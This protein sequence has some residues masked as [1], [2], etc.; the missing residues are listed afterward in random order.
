MNSTGFLLKK[1]SSSPSF[2]NYVNKVLQTFNVPGVAVAIVKDGKVLSAKGYGVKK[3]GENNK[4]DEN[5]IILNCFK[6]K[7]IHSNGNGH[8]CWKK[9]K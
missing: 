4:V 3:S 8:A 9:G 2:D 6:Y 5:T 7:S 1:A